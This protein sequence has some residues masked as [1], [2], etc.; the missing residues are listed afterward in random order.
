MRLHR[1]TSLSSVV[2]CASSDVLSDAVLLSPTLARYTRRARVSRCEHQ[3]ACGD[4][5]SRR[6]VVA[7]DTRR[8]E[9]K[10]HKIEWA[11]RQRTVPCTYSTPVPV[12]E[13]CRVNK[14]YRTT[15]DTEK[16]SAGRPRALAGAGSY[17]RLGRG[18]AGTP[19]RP[20]HGGQKQHEGHE[21]QQHASAPPRPARRGHAAR[22]GTA[23]GRRLLTAQPP[24][25]TS[26]AQTELRESGRVA[27]R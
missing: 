19:R 20:A 6:Q 14:V 17:G 9:K 23:G 18:R 12:L 10:G 26:A 25:R 27:S 5:P 8:G 3:H 16:D 4:A 2:V 22:Q 7:R 21:V 13:T 11:R 15:S 24:L 1:D